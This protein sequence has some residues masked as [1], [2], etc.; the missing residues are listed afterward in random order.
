M[1]RLISLFV[2]ICIHLVAAEPEPVR[3]GTTPEAPKDA[4]TFKYEPKRAPYALGLVKPEVA[5]GLQRVPSK[6]F[7]N[8]IGVVYPPLFD[9]REKA[10]LVPIKNQKSCGSCVSFAVSAID[11]DMYGIRGIPIPELSNQYQMSC[12]KRE[13]MCEGSFFERTASDYLLLGGLVTKASYPY[14]ASNAACKGK[15]SD[16]FGQIKSFK[17][18]D[19]SQKSIITALLTNGPVA[20][21]VGADNYFMGYAGGD[22]NACT[23]A[24]TNHETGI[25]GYKCI[26]L[27]TLDFD[28]NGNLPAGKCYWLMRNSWDVTWGEEGW[29]WIKMTSNSGNRCNNI[30]EEVGIVDIGIPLPGPTPAP[31][32]SPTPGPGPGPT[33]TPGDSHIIFYGIIAFLVVCVGGLIGALVS[34]KKT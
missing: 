7:L 5:T 8:K 27:G 30:T 15:T 6:E 20:T 19:N 24:A 18:I 10:K 9:W 29:M 2:F 3:M 33:P 34:K 25:Y 28:S 14:T 4:F 31:S 13:W 11:E 21:T 16:L 26:G 12:G 17:V 22:Y 32:P 1:M 23:N